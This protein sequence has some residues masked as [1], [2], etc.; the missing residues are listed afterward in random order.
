MFSLSCEC[1]IFEIHSGKSRNRQAGWKKVRSDSNEASANPATG[2]LTRHV[3]N[4]P[5]YNKVLH[6]HHQLH[7]FDHVYAEQPFHNYTAAT[8]QA[9]YASEELIG[10]GC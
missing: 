6:Q 10:L 8:I 2:I 9:S 4:G 1:H 5:P 7:L 3:R